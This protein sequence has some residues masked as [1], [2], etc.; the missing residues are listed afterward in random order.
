M[1]KNNY[2]ELFIKTDVYSNPSDKSKTKPKL[3][4][5]GIITR[6]SCDPERDLYCPA[7][8]IDDKGKIIKNECSVVI[9]ERGVVVVNHSYEE[10]KRMIFGDD[11][12]TNEIGFKINKNIK[13]ESKRK[14]R[15]KND[16]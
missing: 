1:N 15:T 7:E 4:K 13:N 14:R 5:K 16:K 3:I 11:Y 10:L 9:K 2:V 8:L 6:I 12:Q